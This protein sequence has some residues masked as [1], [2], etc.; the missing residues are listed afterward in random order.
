MDLTVVKIK[1]SSEEGPREIILGSAYPPYD[2]AEPPPAKELERLVTWCRVEG[3]HL[4]IGCDANSHH[5][6]WRSTN[7]NNRGECRFNYIMANGL[8]IMNKG[9]RPTF[10]TSKRQE[11]IDIM[12]ANFDADNFIKNWHVSEEASC[13]DHIYI[14]FTVRAIDR[15]IKVYRNP[16]KTD[17]ESFRTDLPGRLYKMTDRINDFAYLET[18]AEQ[19][20]EANN[21][22]YT[23]N[24]PLSMRKNYRNIPWWTQDLTERRRKVRR[25]FNA[26]KKSGN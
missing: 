5:T 14:R 10:V 3:T 6:F 21:F 19:F 18:A 17:W 20:Q 26:A 25:L 15:S 22:A 13:S 16:R 4:I 24:C 1:T 2:D 12:I 11:V 9:N 8:D 23:E 7:T